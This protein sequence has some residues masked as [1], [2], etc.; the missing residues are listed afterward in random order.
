MSQ[1]YCIMF[2]RELYRFTNCFRSMTIKILF[3]NLLELMKF[4]DETKRSLVHAGSSSETKNPQVLTW[5]A[6]YW[7]FQHEY[8]K[9]MSKECL[10]C[11]RPEMNVN[12]SSACVYYFEVVIDDVIAQKALLLISANR[13]KN[14]TIDVA[15]LFNLAE[16]HLMTEAFYDH[17]LKN[18]TPKHFARA[19][20]YKFRPVFTKLNKF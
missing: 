1:S 14:T 6:F 10:K 13:L 2:A 17:V 19:V 3:D 20:N 4:A 12:H 7:I 11:L 16:D 8:Q 9:I 18:V 5:R 15:K